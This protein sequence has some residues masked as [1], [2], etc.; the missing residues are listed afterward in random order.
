[1][2]VVLNLISRP[3]T[4]ICVGL[5]QFYYRHSILVT[6]VTRGVSRYGVLGMKAFKRCLSQGTQTFYA[7]KLPKLSI[8]CD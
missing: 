5:S 7:I 8:K 4:Y 2:K 6:T 1:M 3:S